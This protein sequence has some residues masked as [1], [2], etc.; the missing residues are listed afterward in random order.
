M[1]RVCHVVLFQIK[2]G[3]TQEEVSEIY[4]ELEGLKSLVSGLVEFS[5]GAYTSKEGLNKNFTHAFTMIFDTEASRD[6]YLPHPEHERVK[7]LIISMI[8]DVV[9]F[10]YLLV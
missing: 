3:V 5:G 7:K 6:A 10:D 2:A 8:D 4:R 9:A 1:S